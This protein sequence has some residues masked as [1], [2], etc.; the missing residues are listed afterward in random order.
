M[1]KINYNVTGHL[2]LMLEINSGSL[3]IDEENGT[4][5]VKGER[6]T[7]FLL[8][9]FLAA[10]TVED[11]LLEKAEEVVRTWFEVPEVNEDMTYEVN[12]RRFL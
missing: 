7:Q 8:E 9:L 10:T 4:F 12:V 3:W 2:D 11:E 5:H 6:K 1:R